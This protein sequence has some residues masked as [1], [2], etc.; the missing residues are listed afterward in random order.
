MLAHFRIA[1]IG[2]VLVL[3]IFG[4]GG[5]SS[6]GAVASG[7]VLLTFDDGPNPEYT[8]LILSVLQEFDIKAVFFVVGE[9]VEKYPDLLQQVHQAGHIIGNH[10][11]T[12]QTLRDMS[13]EQLREEITRTDRLIRSIT[14]ETPAY[15][16]PPRGVYEQREYFYLTQLD[17]L[18]LM[19]D[20]GLEKADIHSARGL[21]DHILERMLKA[22]GSENEF[23][24][25]L[26]DGDPSGQYDRSLTVEAL[27]MLIQD[28]LESG[29]EFI[30]PTSR[31]GRNFIDC[32]GELHPKTGVY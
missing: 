16:R 28:L 18:P 2:A 29:Y 15:V 19:W 4:F 26:H 5:Q 7:K 23:I 9:E 3:F 13:Q 11:Y 25:L 22:P 1:V 32:Y 8:G 10:T 6:H 30:D 14:G 27:P 20:F 12:H 21:V 31:E 17:K 24:L